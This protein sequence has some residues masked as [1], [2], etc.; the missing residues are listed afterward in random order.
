VNIVIFVVF[1][2]LLVYFAIFTFNMCI[3]A[4]ILGRLAW[5]D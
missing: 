1:F 5:G 3:I 4:V 2:I